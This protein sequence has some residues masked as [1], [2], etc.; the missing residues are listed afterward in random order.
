MALADGIIQ[1]EEYEMLAKM[2]KEKGISAEQ[3]S[4]ALKEVKAQLSHTNSSDLG[5]GL[6]GNGSV[7]PP[8]PPPGWPWKDRGTVF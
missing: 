4:A 8:P 1:K 3:H 2:R 5:G 6:G 7:P